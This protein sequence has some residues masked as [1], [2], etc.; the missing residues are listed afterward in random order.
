MTTYNDFVFIILH[1]LN[2]RVARDTRLV[3]TIYPGGDGT[4]AAVKAV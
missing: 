1:A 3:S 2:Q 4:L